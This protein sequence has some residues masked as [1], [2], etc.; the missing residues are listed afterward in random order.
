MPR[1]LALMHPLLTAALTLTLFL[2]LLQFSQLRP[3]LHSS[4]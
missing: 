4:V 1:P 3:G 2:L